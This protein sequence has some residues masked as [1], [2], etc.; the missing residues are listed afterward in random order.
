MYVAQNYVCYVLFLSG[1]GVRSDARGVG[2]RAD[3]VERD[4]HVRGH[5]H[6]GLLRPHGVRQHDRHR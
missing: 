6:A 2:Q 4:V 5:R 1:N 3:E